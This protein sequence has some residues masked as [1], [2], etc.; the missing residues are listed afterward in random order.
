M[1]SPDYIEYWGEMTDDV[2]GYVWVWQYLT[3]VLNVSTLTWSYSNANSGDVLRSSVEYDYGGGAT[4]GCVWN[5]I[6]DPDDPAN[7]IQQGT[8]HAWVDG[9][10]VTVQL[11][12]A[13][14]SD[15]CEYTIEVP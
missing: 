15:G 9:I 6:G 1:G 2:G 4:W 3:G 14:F 5:G 7:Y 13:P 10:P 12:P 11:T 8:P